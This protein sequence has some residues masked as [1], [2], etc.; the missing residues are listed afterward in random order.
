MQLRMLEMTREA[1]ELHQREAFRK[2]KLY[3]RARLR[4]AFMKMVESLTEPGDGQGWEEDAAAIGN[5]R[6]T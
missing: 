3:E 5:D 6:G 2:G 1:F 4:A